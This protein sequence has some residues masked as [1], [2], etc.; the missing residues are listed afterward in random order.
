MREA[1]TSNAAAPPA[2]P[3]SPAM[4]CGDFI[5]V[6]GQIALDPVTGKLIEGDAA[7]QAERVITN[8]ETVLEGAGRRLA[9]AVRVGVFLT[10]IGDF[11]TVN[12]VYAR[13]FAPPYPA[14]TTVAVAALP[15]GGKVEIDLVAA[16]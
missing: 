8:L 11:A 16:S 12:A 10:D 1:I 14:R 5:Y 13:R 15:L 7:A 9:D 3:Y 2:G 6:S 4:R